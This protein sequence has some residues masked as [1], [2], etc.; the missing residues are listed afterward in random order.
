MLKPAWKKFDIK[1]LPEAQP[2]K[3][4]YPGTLLINKYLTKKELDHYIEIIESKEH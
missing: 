3:E 4:E 1:E 2:S